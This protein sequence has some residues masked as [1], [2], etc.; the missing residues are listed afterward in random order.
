MLTPARAESQEIIS[1]SRKTGDLSFICGK[2]IATVDGN[3]RAELTPEI[4]EL[5]VAKSGCRPRSNTPEIRVGANQ[6]TFDKFVANPANSPDGPW[7]ATSVWI[8]PSSV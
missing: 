6:S 5:T 7:S 3:Q 2:A 1:N 4:R 8:L